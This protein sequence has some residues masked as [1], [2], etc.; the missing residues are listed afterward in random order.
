M[1]KVYDKALKS[2]VFVCDGGLTA[3]T[4]PSPSPKPYPDPVRA[5]TLS[6]P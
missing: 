5:L 1:Q 3:L 4:L 2:H 6:E